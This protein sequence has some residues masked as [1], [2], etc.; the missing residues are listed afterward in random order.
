MT[1]YV[2]MDDTPVK[3]THTVYEA[4]D[5]V[6]ETW[7]R[8]SHTSTICSQAIQRNEAYETFL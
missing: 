2:N 1:L 4:R 3:H 7:S 5:P 8:N 6:R